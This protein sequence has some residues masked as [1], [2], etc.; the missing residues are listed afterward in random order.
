MFIQLDKSGD[1]RLGLNEFAQA[2]PTLARWGI[3]IT[4]AQASFKEIDT[5]GGGIVLF[6]EFVDWAMDKNL[7]LEDDDEHPNI[8]S[9]V[10]SRQIN[11]KDSNKSKNDLSQK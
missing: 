9:N 5:N 4:D 2:V 7:D 11:Q 1:R 3:K 10:K 8:N 6:D